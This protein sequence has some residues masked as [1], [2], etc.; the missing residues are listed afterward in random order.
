MTLRSLLAL[1]LTPLPLFFLLLLAAAWFH[2]RGK[3]RPARILAI[4]SLA[5]LLAICTEPLPRLSCWL[6]ERQHP[7]LLAPPAFP[8]GD[9]VFVVVLGAGYSHHPGRPAL[10]QSSLAGL[11]RLTEGIR[12]FRQLPGPA[13]LV[14]SGYGGDEPRSNAELQ[15]DAAVELGVPASSIATLPLPYNT[16]EE[17]LHFRQRFGTDRNVILV[18]DAVHLPRSVLWFERAGQR[19]TPAPANHW[20]KSL[21]MEFPYFLLPRADNVKGMEVSMH[22]WVGLVVAGID[23]D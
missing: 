21:E 7:A 1:P 20:V 19:V 17:S 10:N 23:R 4:L 13:V 6:L 8:A 11:A 16:Q 22:E 14:T 2:R 18:T 15:R 9:T 3:R 12:L 5:W